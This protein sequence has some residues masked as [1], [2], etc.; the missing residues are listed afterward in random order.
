MDTQTKNHPH[1]HYLT[2]EDKVE[3]KIHLAE[4]HLHQAEDMLHEAEHELEDA[5]HEQDIIDLERDL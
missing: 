1:A 5:L 3:Q 2:E 4:E